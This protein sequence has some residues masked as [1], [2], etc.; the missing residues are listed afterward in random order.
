MTSILFQD[1]H[2]QLLH[3]PGNS[4]YAVATFNG[5]NQRADGRSFWGQVLAERYGIECFAFMTRRPNWFPATSMA[6]AAQVL[7]R[8]RRGALL[9]YGHS[10][11]GYACLR[12]S[13]LLGLAGGI[14][15]APLA[16][17]APNE[18]FGD[19]RYSEDYDP[20]LHAEMLVRP[21]HLQG[22]L[23]LAY[24]PTFA[25]DRPH[26]EAV[27]GHGRN[28]V[29]L[30][31]PYLHHRTVL[32]LKPGSVL[33]PAFEAIL[34]GRDLAPIAARARRNAKAQP[35]YRIY[36]ARALLRSGRAALA[37]ILLE[38][39]PETEEADTGLERRLYLA[40]ACARTGAVPRAVTL[41]QDLVQRRPE[42][43]TYRHELARMS[44]M[45]RQ[46]A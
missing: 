11:G 40:R 39:L 28:V 18:R 8:H 45:V 25:E 5:R 14:A 29:G 17:I 13:G 3:A 15:S 20:L 31:L 16:S 44:R 34:A 32:A 6:A 30:P 7:A 9:G 12:Y 2:L 43:P 33:V 46:A 1:D 21:E 19:L 41:M 38:A 23:L 37:R 4:P 22:R 27:I 35:L 10:M 26:A 42:N 24:D 36:L